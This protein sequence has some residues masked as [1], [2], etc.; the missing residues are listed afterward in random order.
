MKIAIPSTAPDLSGQVEQKLGIAAYMLIIDT[1]DM[2]FETVEGPPPSSAQGA[3]IQVLTLVLNMGADVVLVDHLA[4]HIASVLESQNIN[5]IDQVRGPVADVIA[6]YMAAQVPV[7]GVP[8]TEHK[9]ERVASQ[10]TWEDALMKGGRQIASFLPILL[11]VVLLLGLFETFISRE[12]LLSIFSGSEL[13]NTLLAASLGSILA[14]HPINS[15]VIG[16]TLLK[17]GVGLSAVTALMVTWVNIGMLQLPDEAASLGWR[18]SLVRNLAGFIA[19]LLMA[20]VLNYL[21]GVMV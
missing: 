14:G 3:G 9:N 7:K 2:S 10:V 18:F 5:V 8:E 15:Y 11:G 4:P 12:A 1:E 6:A 19:A 20:F 17:A 13:Q 21:M 16:D